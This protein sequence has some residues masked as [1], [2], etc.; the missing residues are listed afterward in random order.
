M[1]WK[2]C[3]E[4]HTFFR[5]IVPPVS[6]SKSLFHLGSRFR[7]SGRTIHQMEESRKRSSSNT[8]RRPFQRNPLQ[9]KDQ[10]P[11]LPPSQS[12]TDANKNGD[13]SKHGSLSSIVRSPSNSSNSI[14]S[15][16]QK[17]TKNGKN[18]EESNGKQN[19]RF[20][21]LVLILY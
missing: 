6:N 2:A 17:A 3:I 12:S 15:S 18:R 7:Y 19:Q 20:V 11:P 8:K 13:T 9:S 1:M 4:H 14:G 16:T 10:K 21:C 5:L